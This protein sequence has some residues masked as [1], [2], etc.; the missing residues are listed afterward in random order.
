MAESESLKEISRLLKESKL[1]ITD[2]NSQSKAEGLIKDEYEQR[3][4]A[5]MDAAGTTTVTNEYGSFGRMEA[6]MPIAKDWEAIYEYVKDNDAFFI[7]YKQLSPVAYRELMKAGEVVP[8][9]DDF[10]KVTISVR[11]PT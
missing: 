10:T 6:V 9:I 7:L 8:G 2:L 1:K 11:K 5:A 3:L 4:I